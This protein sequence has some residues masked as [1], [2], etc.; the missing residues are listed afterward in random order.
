MSEES[1]QRRQFR[2]QQSI[3]LE[4]SR[5]QFI[6]PLPPPDV[7]VRYNEAV[8]NAAERII[9]MAESQL[10]HRQTLEAQVIASNCKAQHR[11]PIYGFIVCMSAIAGGVYLIS[12]GKNA[13]GL[14]SIISALAGLAVVFIA[15]KI[16]QKR[17]LR[18]K[19]EALVA[20]PSHQT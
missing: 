18:Q 9:A 8:P 20:P 2:Q 4:A 10:R 14:A 7:L 16:G 19:N 15:G 13:S 3:R 12:T 11:G 6:G 1:R 17:E 5:T